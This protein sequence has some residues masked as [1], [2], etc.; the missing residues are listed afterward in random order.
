MVSN[1]Y[2]QWSADVIASPKYLKKIKLQEA[3]ALLDYYDYLGL[4]NLFSFLIPDWEKSSD[5]LE[6]KIRD[7]LEMA[8]QWN[9][10]KFA[11]F[12]SARGEAA[13]ARS[14]E[15]WW[16]AYEV[17]YLGVVRLNQGNSVEAMFH[18]FRAVE[19]LLAKWVDEY[20][21]SRKIGQRNDKIQ[22]DREIILP[23]GRRTT[24]VN[25]YGKGLYWCLK[26]CQNINCDRSLEACRK[27]KRDR[28]KDEDIWV[29][30][31]YTLKKKNQLFHQLLGLEEIEV[32]G[33]WYTDDQAD[34][35]ARVLGCLNFVSEQY[36]F[37]S[38]KEASLMSQ[39]HEELKDAIAQYE[40]TP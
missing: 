7:L 21:S 4:K 22:L 18:S 3:K 1:E 29:F 17:A 10:A 33:Y 12:A 39:V 24:I 26:T 19:G 23:N 34:W 36:H 15:W 31:E 16:T 11:E 9:G 28:D 40:L 35:E 20:H 5:P 25:A 8:N 32:F 14:D 6:N 37:T 38:L 27:I 30:G 2:E 13:K